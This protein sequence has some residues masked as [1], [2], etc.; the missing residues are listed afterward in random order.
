MNVNICFFA[1]DGS[2]CAGLWARAIASECSPASANDVHPPSY[3]P[4]P[5]KACKTRFAS[6]MVSMAFFQQQF[7]RAINYCSSLKRQGQ[8][9]EDDQ[10]L[11]QKLLTQK[12]DAIQE[13]LS[14]ITEAFSKLPLFICQLE[15]RT[16]KVN[17]V[18]SIVDQIRVYLN[19]SLTHPLE[20]KYKTAT[21]VLKKFEEMVKQRVAPLFELAKQNAILQ[22]SPCHSIRVESDFSIIKHALGQR[23]HFK[24]DNLTNYL[25]VV[26][27]Q[28]NICPD[29]QERVSTAEGCKEMLNHK[30]HKMKFQ[31]T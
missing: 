28:K 24:G 13:E 18:A 21:A 19:E 10:Y 11:V 12:G 8:T 16:L 23:R 26:L 7:T 4:L 31:I 3:L 30:K 25:E 20:S 14:Y 29:A 22:G 15:S 6:E 9:E 17:Q 5:P 1:L 2:G 27:R